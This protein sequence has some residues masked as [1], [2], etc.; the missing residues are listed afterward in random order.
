MLF[1]KLDAFL[2][3]WCKYNVGREGKSGVTFY[4]RVAG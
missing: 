4:W 1:R 3:M 2:W